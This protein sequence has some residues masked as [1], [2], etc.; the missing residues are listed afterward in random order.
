MAAMG[1]A[2]LIVVILT[3][4]GFSYPFFPLTCAS[5]TTLM[6]HQLQSYTWVLYNIITSLEHFTF[7]RCFSRANYEHSFLVHPFY[8]SE[9]QFFAC[10]HYL[11]VL[12][13]IN[14]L[15]PG[16]PWIIL[17]PASAPLPVAAAV[18]TVPSLSPSRVV[19]TAC[20]RE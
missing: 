1:C 5:S 14:P 17:H 8:L 9:G 15:S 13:S 4:S 18:F 12:L 10:K 20:L 3:A 11:P 6:V 7:V 16:P 19:N 2:S